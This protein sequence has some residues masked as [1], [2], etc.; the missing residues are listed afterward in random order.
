MSDTKNERKKKRRIRRIIRITYLLTSVAI[1]ALLLTLCLKKDYSRNVPEESISESIEIKEPEK[2]VITA[3]ILSAG[4]VMMH[5][6]F[7]ISNQYKSE[8][9][10]YDY[11]NIFKYIKGTYESADFMVVNFESTITNQN[12]KGY[13]RFHAPEAIATA[14]SN[15]SVDLCLLANNHIYDNNDAGMK[16]TMEGMEANSLSYIGI[17]KTTSEKKYLVREING[18]KVGILNYVYANGTEDAKVLNTHPVSAESSPL[19]N[20]FNYGSLQKFYDEVQG[21][22]S[23]MKE[24][25]VQYTIA[26]LHWGAEYSLESNSRQQQIANSLCEIGIDALI[27][28]H[29]HVVQPVDLLTNAAGDHQMLCAYSIGNHLSN[30]YRARID[31][32]PT[33]HTEDGLMV[34][35]V[36]QKNDDDTVSLAKVDFIPTWVYRTPGADDADNPEFYILPLHNKN[37]ILKE[38]SSLNIEKS[39][40]ESLARTKAIIEAGEKKVKDALPI[41]NK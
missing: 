19:I 31:Q 34:N 20:T 23:E 38:T 11:N 9:G 18:I 5:H 12:Y 8:D 26:Y 25:G 21:A 27:G 29:P 2:N 32:L 13:P 35:L 28:A 14:L 6:P 15:N 36:L 7:I 16:M 30:Q 40:N 10:S 37:Q 4:D 39:I 17:R 22:L 41:T 3:S 24:V 1:F 33:G